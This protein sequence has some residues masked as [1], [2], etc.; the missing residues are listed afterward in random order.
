MSSSDK[1]PE[2]KYY[3]NIKSPSQLGMSSD[4]SYGA[5]GNDVAGL[6]AY[7]RL[8]VTGQTAASVTGGPLGNKYFLKTGQQC[9]G[10]DNESADRY[11]YINNVPDGTIPF[12]SQGINENFSEFRGLIPGM[13]SNMSRLNPSEIFSAFT[14][15]STPSCLSISME[16][17]DENN[18]TGQET[19]YVA[20]E[21]IKNMS[22]CWFPSGT[23]PVTNETCRES[24]VGNSKGENTTFEIDKSRMPNDNLV[25]I[26][27]YS[28]GLVGVYILLC[29][30]RKLKK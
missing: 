4:G 23:N 7:V 16:T 5:L 3:N 15:K 27:Y 20:V 1:A 10:P 19:H 22:P 29:L 26:F 12:I 6:I 17:I 8:L 30:L 18:N 2:Y 21:D 25:K 13:V 9:N 14:N 11:I 28:L 24:F